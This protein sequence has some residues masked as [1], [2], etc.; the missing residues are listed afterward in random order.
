MGKKVR[1][2]KKEMLAIFMEQL[3]ENKQKHSQKVDKITLREWWN[4][5]VD[6]LNKD[7]LVTDKQA[8]TWTNPFH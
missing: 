8:H 5:Y 3:K 2:T 4:N 6:S 1:A 7:G